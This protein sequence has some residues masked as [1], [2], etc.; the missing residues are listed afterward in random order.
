MTGVA[1]VVVV[2]VAGVVVVGVAGVVL[3]PY[4]VASVAGS[5]A[6]QAAEVA[7]SSGERHGRLL[8]HKYNASLGLYM[9]PP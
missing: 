9:C 4:S 2:G 5:Q 8:S 6:K 1:G 3:V 7:V